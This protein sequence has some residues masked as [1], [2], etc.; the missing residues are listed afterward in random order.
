MPYRGN[1][2]WIDLLWLIETAS[3]DF[4]AINDL[5]GFGQLAIGRN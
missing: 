1:S 3:N 5:S 4:Y 2:V